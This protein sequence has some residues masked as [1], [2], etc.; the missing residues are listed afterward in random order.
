M[1]KSL[2]ISTNIIKDEPVNC[3]SRS[4]EEEDIGKIS[5]GKQ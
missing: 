2:K 3:S 4:D 5:R 1:K